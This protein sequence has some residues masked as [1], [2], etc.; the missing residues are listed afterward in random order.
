MRAGA[1]SSD[2]ADFI[3]DNNGSLDAAIGRFIALLRELASQT[4]SL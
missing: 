1:W 4:A 3:I 2:Q